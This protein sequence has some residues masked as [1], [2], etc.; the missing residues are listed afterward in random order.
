MKPRSTPAWLGA[1]LTAGNDL[2][3]AYCATDARLQFI[4][5][6]PS[7]LDAAGQPRTDIFE[8]NGIHLIGNGY[9]T[10]ASAVRARLLET[11]TPV[12]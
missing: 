1:A 4:D 2:I 12:A 9:R 8:L 6:V 11:L 7:M 10:L 5:A 3:R